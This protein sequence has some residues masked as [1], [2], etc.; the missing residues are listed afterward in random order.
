MTVSLTQFKNHEPVLARGIGR[1]TFEFT[2]PPT[3]GLWLRRKLER[4]INQSL[5]A[6]V[7][8]AEVNVWRDFAD[9]VAYPV[10]DQ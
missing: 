6:Q 1:L 3:A 7:N 2:A 9:F 4:E 5:L 8:F 10:G